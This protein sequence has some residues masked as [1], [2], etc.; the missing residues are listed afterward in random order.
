MKINTI[1]KKNFGHNDPHSLHHHFK[2][3]YGWSVWYVYLAVNLSLFAT[4]IPVGWVKERRKQV[5]IPLKNLTTE[6]FL[7]F[8]EII[9][10]FGA[11]NRTECILHYDQISLTYFQGSRP[12]ILSATFTMSQSG[13]RHGEPL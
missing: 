3:Q 6:L 13:Q 2:L 12:V 5:Q 10:S 11:K 4:T 7:K 8:T 1:E 9:R